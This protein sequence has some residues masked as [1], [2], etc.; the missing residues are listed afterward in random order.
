MEL[1]RILAVDDEPIM[2]DLYQSALELSGDKHQKAPTFDVILCR[3]GNEAVDTVKKAISNN[4]P[5]SVI[6]L[7]L[8]LP[9]GP[10][11]VWTAEQIRKIDPYVNFVIVT[12][13][14]DLFHP[15]EITSRIPPEDKILYVQKPFSIHEMRQFA[16]SLGTKWRSEAQLRKINEEL[17]RKVEERTAE[18]E[19]TNTQ[20]VRENSERKRAEEALRTAHDDL[21]RRVE[22]RTR[23]VVVINEELKLNQRALQDHKAELEYVNKQLMDANNALSVLARNLER[24]RKES[25][26][27][28][29]SRVRTIIIPFIEKLQQDRNLQRYRADLRLLAGFIE[30]LTSDLSADLKIA[31]TLSA[32]ELHIASLIK[33]GMSSE[34]IARH[35]NVSPD[36][37]KTHRKNIR[38]KLN[39]Q[40]SN[41][42]LRV[43]LESEL[44]NEEVRN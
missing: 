44:G 34:E 21:E 15:M 33:N 35:L 29:I 20:L 14:S 42:N 19:Q 41:L 13:C 26:N 22:E 32:T 1:L 30:N 10:D 2:L 7:D 23:E 12:G 5:F 16:F 37:V 4:K 17:E 39:L 40:D 18:L 27:R 38:R 8:R 24:S 28:T 31:A 36:T 43:Y 25:E 3:Q 11:G 6:F 9:P